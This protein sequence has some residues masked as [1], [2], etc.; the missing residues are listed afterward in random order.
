MK[1]IWII[2]VIGL[3]VASSVL[4]GCTDQTPTHTAQII[5]I[6]KSADGNPSG[7]FGSGSFGYHLTDKCGNIYSLDLGSKQLNYNTFLDL[8]CGK[9]YCILVDTSNNIKQINVPAGMRGNIQKV[10]VLQYSNGFTPRIQADNGINYWNGG[11]N[12]LIGPGNYTVTITL[13]G[14]YVP[15]IDNAIPD[16]Y[17]CCP[18]SC[19]TPLPICTPIPTPTPTC[20][21]GS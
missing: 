10:R 6:Q 16:A 11:N 19:P 12:M 1:T 3:L 8:Q 5:P 13:D 14:Y 21:C 7:R 20:G 9:E 15:Q 4:M 18:T 2:P 17:Q